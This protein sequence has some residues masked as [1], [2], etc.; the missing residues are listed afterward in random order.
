MISRGWQP[1]GRVLVGLYRDGA[2]IEDIEGPNLVVSASRFIHAQL[3]GGSII[4]NTIAQIGFGSNSSGAVFGNTNLSADA[5][6]KAFDSISFP[7]PNQVAFG[8]SL[9][10]TE[11]NGLLLAEYGLMTASGALYARRVRATPIL[12]DL[13]ISLNATWTISF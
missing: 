7:N 6:Y 2:L 5:F 11:A 10:T 9:G 13:S 8:F 12:K 3:V 1:L 4:G